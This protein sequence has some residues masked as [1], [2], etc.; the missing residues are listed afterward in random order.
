MTDV[1]TD[2][3]VAVSVLLRGVGAHGIEVNLAGYR[4]CVLGPAVTALWGDDL[5]AGDVQAVVW[6]TR[7]QAVR[8]AA[9]L[10]RCP[11]VVKVSSPATGTVLGSIWR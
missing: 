6:T 7:A 5:R 4:A 8:A 3:R 1:P 9:E 2:A 10:A 11:G